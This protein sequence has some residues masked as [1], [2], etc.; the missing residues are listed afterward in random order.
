MLANCQVIQTISAVL[1]QKFGDPGMCVTVIHMANGGGDIVGK[2]DGF[3]H[4]TLYFP[5]GTSQ[6]LTD[7]KSISE[8]FR[9]AKRAIMLPIDSIH[10]EL[11]LAGRVY[12]RFL[13]GPPTN[14]E[15]LTTAYREIV[16]EILNA[17]PE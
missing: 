10:V 2:I 6:E 13:P 8:I 9:A 4:A 17:K 12:S 5:D 1:S 7:V 14:P 15:L 11:H 3:N 16:K